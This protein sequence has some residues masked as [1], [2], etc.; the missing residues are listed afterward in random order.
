MTAELIARGREAYARR[1]WQDCWAAL[2]EADSAGALSAPDVVMLAIS[3]YLGGDDEAVNIHIACE[4]GSASKAPPSSRGEGVSVD[5]TT[6]GSRH[7]CHIR[8]RSPA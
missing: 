2:G 6:N 4:A 3:G 1:E 5:W 8:H 7:L